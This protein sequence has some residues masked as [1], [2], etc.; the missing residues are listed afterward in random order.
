MSPLIFN[1]LS[2]FSK[3]RT[4]FSIRHRQVLRSVRVPNVGFKCISIKST[5]AILIGT[6]PEGP[7]TILENNRNDWSNQSISNGVGLNLLNAFC[8][9]G[10]KDRGK[11]YAKDQSEVFRNLGARPPCPC[12]RVGRPNPYIRGDVCH[13]LFCHYRRE[14]VSC[15]TISARSRECG[16][17]LPQLLCLD[18]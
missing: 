15:L 1:D 17:L 10:N 6:E 8:F 18:T 7:S 3:Q 16:K 2:C 13:N 9:N 14:F 11:D 5:Y 12:D 4:R